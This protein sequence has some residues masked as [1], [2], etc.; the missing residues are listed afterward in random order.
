[1]KKILFTFVIISLFS[2]TLINAQQLKAGAALRVITPD[3]LIP[4]SGGVGT[5]KPA[6]IKNGD[7]YVRALV[8]EKGK[9]R[10]AI[11]NIDNKMSFYCCP[12]CHFYYTP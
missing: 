11:V 7:L 6:T 12:K 9:E 10:I 3:P 5:P 2:I 1:M 4:V 8:L